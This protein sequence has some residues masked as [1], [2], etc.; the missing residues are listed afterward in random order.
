MLPS[1]VMVCG[2]AA[3]AQH[4]DCVAVCPW[5]GDSTSRRRVP[6]EGISREISR[7]LDISVEALR[8]E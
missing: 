7:L 6:S 4:T 2:R 8:E 3:N 1:E 5:R